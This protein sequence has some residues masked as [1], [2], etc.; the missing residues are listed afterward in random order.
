MTI[1]EFFAKCDNL[2]PELAA[3]LFYATHMVCKYQGRQH[4]DSGEPYLEH[5][6]DVAYQM[7]EIGLDDDEIV[8]AC[9]HDLVEDT[10]VTID[11]IREFFGEPVAF[12]VEGVTKGPKE[13]FPNKEARLEDLHLRIIEYARVRFGVIFI[14][15]G[16]RLHNLVTLHGLFRDPGKQL[17]VAQETIDFYVQQLLQ[18]EARVIVPEKYHPWLDRYSSKMRHLAMAYLEIPNPTTVVVALRNS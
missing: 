8:G 16:C 4:R 12:N 7:M 17:R 6:F 9:L 3:K 11:L 2:R 10:E 15:C 18:G 5:V 13:K 1:T 14:R